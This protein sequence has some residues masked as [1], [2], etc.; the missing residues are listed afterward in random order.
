MFVWDGVTPSHLHLWEVKSN[1]LYKGDL[2]F[3]NEL[4]LSNP[5]IICL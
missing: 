1:F 4:L 2:L 3:S 5:Q